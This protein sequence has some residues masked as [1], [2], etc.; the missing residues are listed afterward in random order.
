[1][2][3]ESNLPDD[4][5]L[6]ARAQTGDLEA[7]DELVRRHQRTVYNVAYRVVGDTHEASDVAQEVFIRAY[8]ALGNFRGQAKFSTWLYHIAVN[9]AKNHLRSW[10][11]QHRLQT[12]SLEGPADEEAEEERPVV[13]VADP[14]ASPREAAGSRDVAEQVQA[15]LQELPVTYRTVLVLR[16]LQGLSYEEV[17]AIVRA[18]LGT[19]KAHIHRGRLLLREALRAKGWSGGML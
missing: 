8:R 1:M 5:P 14:S 11:R 3:P 18:P 4:A 16:D 10:S 15:A 9:T 19:V 17:A 6:V 13:Q 2:V 7:F 12:V